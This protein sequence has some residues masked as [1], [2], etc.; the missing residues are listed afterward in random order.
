[1]VDYNE[2]NK[3]KETLRESMKHRIDWSI[4]L[5][6]LRRYI[7]LYFAVH[8]ALSDYAVSDDYVFEF[9]PDDFKHTYLLLVSYSDK[10]LNNGIESCRDILDVL[11]DKESN[12]INRLAKL[13]KLDWE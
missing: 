2:L 7:Q 10:Y 1:M 4:K 8:A 5:V 3:A 12:N 13:V 9:I 11:V 6:W